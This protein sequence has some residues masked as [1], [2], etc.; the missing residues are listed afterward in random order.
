MFLWSLKP[1]GKLRQATRP[2]ERVSFKQL[3]QSYYGHLK[4]KLKQS[5]LGL[6]FHDGVAQYNYYSY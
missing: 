2:L 4:K 3:I 5:S 1:L 6:C